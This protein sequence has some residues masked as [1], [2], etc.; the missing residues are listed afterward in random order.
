MA[1]PRLVSATMP[2][3]PVR[4]ANPGAFKV[5]INDSVN[6]DDIDEYLNDEIGDGQY[7]HVFYNDLDGEG[8]FAPA[9]NNNNEYTVTVLDKAGF[10]FLV[11][12]GAFPEFA[13][14][15]EMPNYMTDDMAEEFVECN[16]DL[17]EMYLTM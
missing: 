2:N 11:N 17:F 4:S 9:G 16:E 13:S 12:N 8:V 7:G 6:T 1:S 15:E 3:S 5:R 10:L 14:I